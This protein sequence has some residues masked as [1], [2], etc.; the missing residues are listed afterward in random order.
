[1]RD[2]RYDA[3]GAIILKRKKKKL[4]KLPSTSYWEVYHCLV[5]NMCVYAYIS[6]MESFTIEF[7]SN[8]HDFSF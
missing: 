1:M 2:T 7:V 4:R 6:L 3:Q 8:E 5:I